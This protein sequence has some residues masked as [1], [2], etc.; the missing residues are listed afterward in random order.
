MPIKLERI[1]PK[2]ILEPLIGH[3]WEA[4][5]VFNCA[6]VFHDNSFHLIYRA[7]DI[8]AS[9]NDGPFISKLGY[10]VGSD[11]LHFSRQDEPLLSNEG[12]QELRGLEDPRIVKIEDTFYMMYTAFRGKEA[13]D[14]RI[15]LATSKDLKN[16]KRHGI[17]L[18]ESNKDASLF[19]EK[20][21][22]RFCMFHRRDPDIWIAYSKDL[23]SWTDHT[24]VMEPISA[25]EWQSKKI[26][27]AGPPIRTDK[28]WLLIYHGVSSTSVYTLGIALLDI[29]DPSIVLFRQDEP[30]LEPELEW[31][32]KGCVPNVVFSCGQIETS[33]RILVYYA[34]A[35]KVIGVAGIDKK[36]IVF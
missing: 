15:S 3:N 21:K 20:I 28:G 2:P 18:D 27:I 19:P 24:K 13:G 35:D 33:D 22:G 10:A 8:D 11:G 5:A 1:M 34:G 9:G 36:K 29:D 17:V 7:T 4:A 30:I 23:K 25:I 6:A 32:K 16:W 12:E 31:E 26:G 14:Y